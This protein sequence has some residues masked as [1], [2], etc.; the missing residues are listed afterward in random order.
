MPVYLQVYI[1]LIFLMLIEY[2]CNNWLLIVMSAELH[3]RLGF[4]L[5]W[6]YLYVLI[7][8]L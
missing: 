8:R 2:V 1:S 4:E 3:E 5:D 7:M 6:Y